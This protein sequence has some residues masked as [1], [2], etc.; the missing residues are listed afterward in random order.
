MMKSKV[1][2]DDGLY[3][4]AK[5]ALQVCH[6]PLLFS[7]KCLGRSTN[8]SPWSSPVCKFSLFVCYFVALRLSLVYHVAVVRTNYMSWFAVGFCQV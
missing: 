3:V 5:A 2:V 1:W 7:G 8:R 4:C 6:S